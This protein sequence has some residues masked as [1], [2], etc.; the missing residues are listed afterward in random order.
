MKLLLINPTAPYW[1]VT[2][3]HLPRLATKIFR[4]SMLSS[5]Y[6]AAAVPR[7]VEV[8]IIDEDVEPVNFDTDADIIGISFMTF[9]APHAYEIADKFRNEKGKPVIV[10]GYH[11]TFMPD[12]ALQH[13][14]AVCIGEAEAV[15]PQMIQDFK[16]G[17][18]QR[19]YCNGSV[20]LKGLAVPNR[21]LI[22]KRAYAMVDALQATRGC[23][24]RC[25][26]C[27]ISS[28]FRHEFRGR[29]A[30]EVI[31]ELRT[32]GKY[33]LF[34]DDNITTDT[35]YA[36][37]LFTKMIPLE[38]RWFSQCSI[39]IA[40]D[41]ELLR[42]ACESGCRGLFVGLES[43]SQANLD[44]WL[45]NFC[46]ARDYGWAIDRIHQAGIGVYAGIVLGNDGDTPEI[47]RQTLQFLH[48]SK[49]D[50]LQAT[51][52][53]PFPGTDLFDEMECQGRIVDRDWAHYDFGHVVFEPWNMSRKTLKEGHD[54]LL[55]Q[56]YSWR[57]IISR[58]LAE[59][60][61]LEPATVF[62]ATSLLNLSYR[63][64]LK[65]DGTLKARKSSQHQ[66]NRY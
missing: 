61:Y 14:D 31:D 8:E 35:D 1:R 16:L 66:H 64:R 39:S 51:I 33:V 12:E 4:Y 58:I 50:A 32:L 26:F 28:F 63:Y 37:E 25:K 53:T 13:A 19:K 44:G 42:L 15:V 48:G 20:N 18:L 36:K 40:Y 47:F 30:D 24:Y 45:K 29:P 7:D 46:K 11:P 3:D 21:R 56:F 6:V 17:V 22:R 2:A 52:L 54:S 5:L 34:M 9:N 60:E 55:E 27:S 10:G 23:P 43:M 57:S 38:K 62:R 59:F 49:V 41:N 65:A